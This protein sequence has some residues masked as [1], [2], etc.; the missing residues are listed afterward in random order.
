MP[1]VYKNPAGLHA[2]RHWCRQ[3]LAGEAFPL[4]SATLA[5]SVG[6]VELDRTR[7]GGHPTRLLQFLSTGD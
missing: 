5:T 1:S 4:T 2:V 6:H 3:A 7:F